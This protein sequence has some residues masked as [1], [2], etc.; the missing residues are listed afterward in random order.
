MARC[1]LLKNGILF[2][3]N[4]NWVS[5]CNWSSDSPSRTSTQRY[6]SGNT[7]WGCSNSESTNAD[8][9][10]AE[11]AAMI[12][13]RNSCMHSWRQGVPDTLAAMTTA[14]SGSDYGL[15]C[16]LALCGSNGTVTEGCGCC[17]E[18]R[19]ISNVLEFN[20]RHSLLPSSH[21]FAG[22]MNCGPQSPQQLLLVY[23]PHSF[24]Y[25]RIPVETGL[26][27]T[28][29]GESNRKLIT[30]VWPRTEELEP[31][32]RNCVRVVWSEN[33]SDFA[34]RQRFAIRQHFVHGMSGFKYSLLT[35][36]RFCVK[37]ARLFV[38]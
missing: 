6:Y 14:V 11:I 5:T 3:F 34:I 26:N 12:A 18:S 8:D 9:T 38:F 23:H 29:C 10:L 17:P 31:R 4:L 16:Y 27:V 21:H 28:L 1:Y 13:A 33:D 20:K 25:L 32:Y 15:S 30:Y 24:E 35:L 2:K 37:S 22:C 19:E 36:L 7:H